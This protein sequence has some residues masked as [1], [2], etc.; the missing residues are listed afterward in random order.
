MVKTT[1]VIIIYEP[2]NLKKK[3]LRYFKFSKD[4]R[5]VY[6][7]ILLFQKLLTETNFL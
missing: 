4:Y 2:S 5:V 1:V 6:A 3:S 7:R